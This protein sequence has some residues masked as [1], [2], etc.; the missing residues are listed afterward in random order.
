MQN[1]VIFKGE[2]AVIPQALR[3]DIMNRIHSSHIGI[4]GCLRRA[5]ES[6]YWPRMNAEV[7]DFIQKCETCRTF[8]NHQSKEP[9]KPHE[10]PARPWA[11]IGL[12]LFSFDGRTY[13]IATDYY[14]NFFEID[15]LDSTT[16]K[17]V[18][19][20]LRAQFVRHGIPDTCISDNGPQ[21]A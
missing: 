2:R 14:S 15:Q 18:I 7:R 5:R 1:G 3:M 19:R 12:D 13:L 6:V 4:E 9:L 20:K 17:D 11:K 21:F 8:D 16:S 10:V